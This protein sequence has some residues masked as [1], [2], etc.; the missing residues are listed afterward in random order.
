MFYVSRDANCFQLDADVDENPRTA[1]TVELFDFF[2]WPGTALVLLFAWL[3]INNHVN[4]KNLSSIRKRFDTCHVVKWPMHGDMLIALNRLRKAEKFKHREFAEYG[5]DTL[6]VR[7][8]I[9]E[10]KKAEFAILNFEKKNIEQLKKKIEKKY[11]PTRKH[12]FDGIFA[13]KDG[14]NVFWSPADLVL[15]ELRHRKLEQKKMKYHEV[16]VD[17]IDDIYG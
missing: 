13:K 4:I 15:Y 10:K 11:N 9:E 14:G 17:S 5:M 2:V 6:A 8:A 7:K 12:K 1:G 16:M 3:I